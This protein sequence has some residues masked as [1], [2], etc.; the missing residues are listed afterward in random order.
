M[1]LKVR[2]DEVLSKEMVEAKRDH[3]SDFLQQEGITPNA[4]E[5]SQTELSERQLKELLA[6]LADDVPG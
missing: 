5:L 6:E 3:I 1:A 2:I 4:V